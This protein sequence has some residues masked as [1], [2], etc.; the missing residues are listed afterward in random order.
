[1][2]A[3]ERRQRLCAAGYTPIPLFGKVPPNKKNN[4]RKSLNEWEQIDNVTNEM[5]VMWEK[6]WPD[7]RNTGLLTR[8][9]P[10]LDLDIL[11]EEAV[12]TIEERA[13]AL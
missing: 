1:M 12:R 10:T 4:P 11:N 5:L 8:L 3:T 9:M 2:N 13:R 6:T 7:A